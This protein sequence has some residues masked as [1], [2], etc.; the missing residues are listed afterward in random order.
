MSRI[1]GFINQYQA[2]SS[3]AAAKGTKKTDKTD[4]TGFTNTKKT[5]KTGKADKTGRNNGSLALSDAA[6]KLLEQLGKQFANADIHVTDEDLDSKAVQDLMSRGTKEFSIVMS[7]DELEKMAADESYLGDKTDQIKDAMEQAKSLVA[8]YGPDSEYAQNP[9][10]GYIS[11][12]GIVFNDDGTTTFFAEM[13]RAQAAGNK[14]LEEGAAKRA[15]ARAEAADKA[16]DKASKEDAKDT[17]M[18]TGTVARLPDDLIQKTTVWGTS[19]EGLAQMISRIDWSKIAA[20]KP[21]T[22]GGSFDF[23]V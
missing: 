13:Q 6:K 1:G 22:E 11:R 21:Q 15:E 14:T 12:V 16:A 23:A 3:A 10:N 7:T 19:R 17:Q 18:Q 9:E 2:V 5:S 8:D 20:E 4:K